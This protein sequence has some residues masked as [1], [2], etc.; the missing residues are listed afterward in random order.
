VIG[1]TVT[2]LV[3]WLSPAILGMEKGSFTLLAVLSGIGKNTAQQ[4]TLS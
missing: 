2:W 4:Q 3:L 1:E